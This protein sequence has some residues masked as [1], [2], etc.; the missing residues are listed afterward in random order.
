MLNSFLYRTALPRSGVAILARGIFVGL[1]FGA[2]L[3]ASPPAEAAVAT[4]STAPR[5]TREEAANVYTAAQDLRYELIR[6]DSETNGCPSL[7]IK[8][9]FEKRLQRL[10]DLLAKLARNK[11][12]EQPNAGYTT[13]PI[14]YYI[15]NT[16]QEIEQAREI[17][18]SLACPGPTFQIGIA[19]GFTNFSGNGTLGFRDLIS[20]ETATTG[21]PYSRTAGTLGFL[22]SVLLPTGNIPLP[23]GRIFFETGVVFRFG[24]GVTATF[25][26]FSP[27]LATG[28]TKEQ[29]NWS[30][31][32]IGGVSMPVTNFGV[33]MPNVSLQIGGGG[34][35]DNRSVKINFFE[36]LPTLQT[37][38]STTTTQMNPAAMV[39]LQYHDPASRWT[40]GVQSI[41]DFQQPVSFTT[42]SIPFPSAVYPLNTGHQVAT[43]V[44]F[45][46]S[47]ST[48][49]LIRWLAHSPPP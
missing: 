11:P 47:V 21:Q 17:L 44:L 41:F 19:G 25:D 32:I 22:G 42:P 43:T 10:S 12:R 7:A 37:S 26:A 46:A 31:P 14:S 40:L 8:A 38:N 33:A 2:A 39:G 3:I 45:N 5:T 35:M 23:N 29:R 13:S 4:K 48:N 6:V 15:G 18:D 34:M 24:N 9:S 20:D 16:T 49:T 27:N 30:V 1:A 28:A 36:V